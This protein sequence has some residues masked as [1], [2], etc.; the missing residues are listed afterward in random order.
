MRHT[1]KPKQRRTRGL[2][3]F[4]KTEISRA[5]QGMLDAGLTLRGVEVDPVTGKFRV[6]VG[7][8]KGEDNELD[9]W[10]KGRKDA[11]PA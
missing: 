3:K 8:A 7:D 2:S 6:L 4:R 5:A 11:R 9:T 1:P 10:L